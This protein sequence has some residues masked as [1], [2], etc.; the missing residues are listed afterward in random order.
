MEKGRKCGQMVDRY[1]MSTKL[2]RRST[3]EHEASQLKDYL[4]MGCVMDMVCMCVK[5]ARMKGNGRVV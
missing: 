5:I 3:M 2:E 4:K 1:V